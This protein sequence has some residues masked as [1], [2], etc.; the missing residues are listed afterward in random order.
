MMARRFTLAVL[1]SFIACRHICA[2]ERRLEDA[3]PAIAD[4][5]GVRIGFSSQQELEAKWGKGKVVT[6]GHPNS[7]RLWKLKGTSWIVQTDGFE[8]SERGLV[9]DSLVLREETKRDKNIPKARLRGTEFRWM[10][11]ISLGASRTQ[12]ADFLRKQRLPAKEADSVIET[13]AGGLS[14][15]ENQQAFKKWRVRLE[16]KAERLSRLSIEAG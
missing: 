5:A 4:V 3:I 1:I 7:G 11:E 2:A 12:V 9:I 8:Y 15:L 6:G 14:S 16:F 13:W 10:S